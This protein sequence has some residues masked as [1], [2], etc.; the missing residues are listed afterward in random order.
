M[1]QLSFEGFELHNEL[2]QHGYAL[3][4]HHIPE[5]AIDEL[6]ASY[7]DFTD[8]L[9]DPSLETIFG[10]IKNPDHLDDLN[11][12]KDKAP[13]W[14]KYR[15]NHPF[16]FKPGG[17][18]NRS[19][20][21]RALQQIGGL[22]VEDD[23]KE[24]YHFLPSGLA[25]I[26]R[27]H[28]EFGWGPLPR[29]VT[30]LHTHF[31]LVHSLGAE[32]VTRVFRS[33]EEQHPELLSKYI[34]PRDLDNSPVRLLFYHPGQGD[35]LA[36][37]HFDKSYGTIQIAES[38]MGLRLRQPQP[39]P[40]DMSN[41]QRRTEIKC[42]YSASPIDDP[43]MIPMQR[44]SNTGIFFP[45]QLLELD[46]VHP[47]SDV[48]AVWHDVLNMPE[49][50]PGRVLRGRNCARWAIIFFANSMIA[51]EI[52]KALTHAGAD[53]LSAAATAQLNRPSNEHVA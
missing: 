22:E 6:I 33:M 46:H 23:P 50:N 8:K 17:Y 31:M 44:D 39:N 51:G 35:I 5:D 36:G 7:A 26:N 42:Q 11:Y 24:Y 4:D 45:S 19:L 30:Q 41:D 10:M 53:L 27:R 21:T 48:K 40:N 52:D 28:A 20:Q 32:A 43:A 15:T 29:E 3:V 49:L 47:G 9:P 38:H 2:V 25:A 18:T 14:H 37:G 16:I 1:G 34:T 13:N 12:F